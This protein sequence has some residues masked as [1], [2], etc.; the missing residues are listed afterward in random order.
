MNPL[1]I[2][3]P[4]RWNKGV[5][6]EDKVVIEIPARVINDCLDFMF[7]PPG[8][9]PRLPSVSSWVDSWKRM[10]SQAPGFVCLRCSLSDLTDQELRLVYAIIAQSIGPLNHRYG[11]FFDVKDH[12][13]DHTKSPVPI[14]KTRACSG[15][16]TDSS[17]LEYSPEVVGLLCLHPGFQGGESLLANAADLYY[18]LC[19]QHPERLFPLS[20]PAKRD[21]ITPGSV[22]NTAEIDRN[23]FPIFQLD[24]RGL[25]FRY[26]RFWITTAYQKLKRPMPEGLLDA[27]DHIDRFLDNDT[28]VFSRKLDRGEILFVNNRHLC[29]SRTA[30]SDR[31][32]GAPPRTLVRTWIDHIASTTSFTPK[33]VGRYRNS[34]GVLN[35]KTPTTTSANTLG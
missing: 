14:S 28:H 27:M 12:G 17:A 30:F 21:V 34:N 20:R 31:Y 6:T 26:M 9:I 8:M 3:K 5:P 2:V 19:E 23:E 16:H 13:L 15:F 11:E 25:H 7:S 24:H 22:Q 33:T 35:Q 18:W 10:L 32:N 4:L 29:H 1:Q